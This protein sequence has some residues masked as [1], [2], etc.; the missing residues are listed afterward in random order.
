FNRL[1]PDMEEVCLH[2]SHQG[3]RFRPQTGM[4][5]C[6]RYK[7]QTD[8]CV[9]FFLAEI[10]LGTNKYDH[11]FPERQRLAEVP[12]FAGRAMRYEP[13]TLQLFLQ[14]IRIPDG[15]IDFRQISPL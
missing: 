11:R 1:P 6:H 13:H 12:F 2:A 8:C 3:G 4:A 10:T 15:R 7:A 5:E 14:E 9:D